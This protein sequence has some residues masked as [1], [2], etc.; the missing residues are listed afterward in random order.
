MRIARE[1]QSRLTANVLALESREGA[2]TVDQAIMIAC[3]LCV[4]RP[5][6]QEGFR[7]YLAGR[8]PGFDLNKL[9]LAAT[10]THAAPVLLQDRYDVKDYGDAMQPKEYVP[11]L[12]QK[13]GRGGCK[14]LGESLQG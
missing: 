1:I 12:Y 4:I 11:W 9:F 10:H 3:D 7:K 6:I 8:L 13:T 14:G 5:G 2:R